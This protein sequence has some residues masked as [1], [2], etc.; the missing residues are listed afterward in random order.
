MMFALLQDKRKSQLEA[1]AAAN[2]VTID[3][4][5]ECMNTILGSGGGRTIKQNKE[6]SPPPTNANSGGNNKAKKVMRKKKLCPH[7]NM[8]MFHK[9]DRCYK[10]GVNKD[11]RWVGWKLVKEAL[12]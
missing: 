12:T 6:N 4:M 7:C 9:P 3:A 10:L 8:F 2:N 1:M 5:M 11:K